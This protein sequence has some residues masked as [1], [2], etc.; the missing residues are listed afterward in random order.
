MCGTESSSL[1]ESTP[2]TSLARSSTTWLAAA[3]R[4]AVDVDISD[5]PPEK[6]LRRRHAG[7][8]THHTNGAWPHVTGCPPLRQ[9]LRHTRADRQAA[10][11]PRRLDAEEIHQ[12]LD[13]VL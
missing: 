5:D 6:R 2:R 10:G 7:G 4:L 3:S 8:G 1:L 9:H 12:A 11:E 13:A